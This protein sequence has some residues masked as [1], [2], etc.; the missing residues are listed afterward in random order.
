MRIIPASDF[1][2]A[3]LVTARKTDEIITEIALPAWPAD[4]KWGFQEFARR[5][6]DFA[7]A[8]AALFFDTGSDGRATNTHIAAIGVG[9]RPVRL[10]DV[11]NHVN[12]RVIDEKVIEKAGAVAAAAVDPPGDLHAGP[13]YRRA[14]LG[15]MVKRALRDAVKR[16]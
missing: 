4:R 3:P 5:R 11:E 16:Q 9:D 7:M 13:D 2:Q 15:T 14:L 1:F 6:G 12:G 10:I 8:G